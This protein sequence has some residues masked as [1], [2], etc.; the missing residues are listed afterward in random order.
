MGDQEAYQRRIAPIYDAIDARNWKVGAQATAR[1][2]VAP[3]VQRAGGHLTAISPSAPL[4][5]LAIKLCNAAL[6]KHPASAY[7]K[8][9]KSLSLVRSGKQEEAWEVSARAQAPQAA[10]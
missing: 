3:R 7:L 10:C 9:L 6:A 5:Q 2:Q 4:A 1:R 8:T